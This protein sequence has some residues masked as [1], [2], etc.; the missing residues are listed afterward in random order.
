MM[1]SKLTLE[2]RAEAAILRITS[3][4]GC[5]R[6]PAEET[7]PDLVIG[8]L[9]AEVKRLRNERDNA[10]GQHRYMVQEISRA[11]GVNCD[12]PAD[13]VGVVRDLVMMAEGWHREHREA[14]A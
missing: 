4:A 11:S 7:D 8:D 10:N 12:S 1:E 2:Q 6:V 9:L 14:G 13:A 5:M 3:G